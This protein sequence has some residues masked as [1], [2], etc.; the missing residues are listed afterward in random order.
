MS[1]KPDRALEPRV[2]PIPAEAR[3]ILRKIADDLRRTPRPAM[4]DPAEVARIITRAADRI[5]GVAA[6][7]RPAPSPR[8][9]QA[10]DAASRC[11][12]GS[13]KQRTVASADGR[14]VKVGT[15]RRSPS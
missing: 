12:A 10:D 1:R 13:P 4:A 3:S 2:D 7:S 6:I 8:A 5:E 11:G 9:W 15:W 14:E